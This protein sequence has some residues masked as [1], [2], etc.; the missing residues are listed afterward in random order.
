MKQMDLKYNAI[1]SSANRLYREENER[2]KQSTDFANN[3]LNDRV[4]SY[5]RYSFEVT[6]WLLLFA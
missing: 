3:P 5:Q 2:I 1:Q 4:Q 6:V